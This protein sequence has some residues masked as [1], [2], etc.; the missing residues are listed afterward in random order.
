MRG[1]T[2]GV[3]GDGCRLSTTEYPLG[4]GTRE[5]VDEEKGRGRAKRSKQGVVE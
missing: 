4:K 1:G 2:K 5:R 3:P